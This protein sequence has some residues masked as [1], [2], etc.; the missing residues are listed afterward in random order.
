MAASSCRCPISIMREL[1]EWKIRRSSRAAMKV[2]VSPI[3]G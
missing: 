3:A 2:T 1:L